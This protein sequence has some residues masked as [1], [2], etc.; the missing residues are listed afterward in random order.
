M[1]KRGLE[2]IILKFH[3]P[4]Q[5]SKFLIIAPSNQRILGIN[6]DKFYLLL[7]HLE[8]FKILGCFYLYRGYHSRYLGSLQAFIRQSVG[9]CQQ[10]LVSHQT[11]T[12]ILIGQMIGGILFS[13]SVT[14]AFSMFPCSKGHW[15]RAYLDTILKT[16]AHPR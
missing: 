9:S 12:I 4:L 7:K 6:I 3:M 13:I 2:K 1:V 14:V 8:I 5:T 10:S 15:V 11:I 16:L